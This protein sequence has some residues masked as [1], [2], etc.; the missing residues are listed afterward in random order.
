MT[1]KWTSQKIA[2]MT[3]LG[4]GVVIDYYGEKFLVESAKDNGYGAI[5]AK[6]YVTGRIVGMDYNQEF[7]VE[8]TFNL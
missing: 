3:S 8:T 7:T 2:E 5:E 4:V 1:V 6:H